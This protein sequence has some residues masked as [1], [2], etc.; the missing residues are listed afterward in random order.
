MK[1]NKDRRNSV[2]YSTAIANPTKTEPSMPPLAAR[3]PHPF[4]LG[5]AEAEDAEALPPVGVGEL[6]DFSPVE[7]PPDLVLLPPDWELALD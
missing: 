7:F 4:F 3:R 5:G 2:Y 6:E 1:L